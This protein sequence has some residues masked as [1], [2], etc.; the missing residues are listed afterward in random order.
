MNSV[1]LFL[2]VIS[3]IL[4][5]S[6]L[7]LPFLSGRAA[8]LSGLEQQSNVSL[9]ITLNRVGQIALV[10]A[11]LTGG[12]MISTAGVSVAF[13]ITAIILVLAIGATSGI[14][15][16]SLKKMLDASKADSST[17]VPASKVQTFSWLSAILILFIVYIMT[18]PAVFG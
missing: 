8:A 7:V 13:M 14:M 18:H 3:A 12:A 1:M 4:M 11:L 2:H 9:L 17:S 15:G 5:G 6:Y 10:V 16:S